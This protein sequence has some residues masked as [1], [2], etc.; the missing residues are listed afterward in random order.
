METKIQYQKMMILVN[1]L[2]IACFVWVG[3]QSAM[4]QMR[5]ELPSTFGRHT[6]EVSVGYNDIDRNLRFEDWIHWGR[7]ALR[8]GF[9]YTLKT[10][11]NDAGLGFKYRAYPQN[12]AQH[13]GIQTGYSYEWLRLRS[14]VSLH[15][16]YDLQV[17][18][19]PILDKTYIPA[20]VLYDSITNQPNLIST[21]FIQVNKPYLVIEQNLGVGLTIPLTKRLALNQMLGMGLAIIRVTFYSISG[22]YMASDWIAPFARIGLCWKFGKVPE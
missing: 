16:F 1:I 4:G 15:S 7:N 19:V 10:F 21:R 18:Y 12:F 2:G 14:G 9:K 11:P 5:T 22:S 13:F 3:M 17:S 20:G 6:A 8:V